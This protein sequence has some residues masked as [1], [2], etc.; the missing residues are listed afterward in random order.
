MFRLFSIIKK[1]C[2]TGDSRKKTGSGEESWRNWTVG[3]IPAEWVEGH[4]Q[5]DQSAYAA[6]LWPAWVM[7]AWVLC[8][9]PFIFLV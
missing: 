1:L 9:L 4:H 8:Q 5:N 7:T 3:Q 2:N 6:T